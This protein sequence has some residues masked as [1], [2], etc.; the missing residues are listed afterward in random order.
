MSSPKSS[1]ISSPHNELADLMEQYIC[2]PGMQLDMTRLKYLLE[3][4]GHELAFEILKKRSGRYNYTVF[5][6]AALRNHCDTMK[7]FLQAIAQELR[8]EALDVR[9]HVGQTPLHRAAVAGKRSS[10]KQQLSF[11]SSPELQLEY[12]QLTDDAGKCA[13]ERAIHFNVFQTAILLQTQIREISNR[14]AKKKNLPEVQVNHTEEDGVWVL[15]LNFQ[16]QRRRYYKIK[17][18]YDQTLMDN[19]SLS[20]EALQERKN[21][22]Q[23]LKSDAECSCEDINN[24]RT[25]LSNAEQ[26]ADVSNKDE[27]LARLEKLLNLHRR[28]CQELNVLARQLDMLSLVRRQSQK[29]EDLSVSLQHKEQQLKDQKERLTALEESQR[30]VKDVAASTAHEMR[31]KAGACKDKLSDAV[32]RIDYLE[33]T[34]LPT[35][36]K[37]KDQPLDDQRTVVLHVPTDELM[38]QE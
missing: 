15:E 36:G 12:I 24:H 6:C 22:L 1:V 38:L 27:L 26:A 32:E 5:H 34:G 23:K 17:A 37:S 28:L 9:D 2:I 33:K 7:C 13:R 19:V 3:A 21:G 8:Y 31:E 30:Q 29:I 10:I 35:V 16:E 18:E 14:I 11:L 25:E 4:V 20:L